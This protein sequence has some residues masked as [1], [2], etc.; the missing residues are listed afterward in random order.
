MSEMNFHTKGPIAMSQSTA[1]ISWPHGKNLRVYRCDS[2]TV[3]EKCYDGRAWTDG[4][5]T[6]PGQHVSATCITGGPSL[7]IWV[8]VTNNGTTTEY[9]STDGATWNVGGYPG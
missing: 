8:Y 1:A 4:A 7:L 9:Y 5:F 3:T 6:A 2:S